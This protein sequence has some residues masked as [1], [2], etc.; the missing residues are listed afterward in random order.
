MHLYNVYKT[1]SGNPKVF[2]DTNDK[3]GLLCLMISNKRSTKSKLVSDEVTART[4][5]GYSG[6][7]PRK[8]R[9]EGVGMGGL[10]DTD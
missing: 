2:Y 5:S 6:L 7:L 3:L 4:A 8:P 10:V 9:L 1:S